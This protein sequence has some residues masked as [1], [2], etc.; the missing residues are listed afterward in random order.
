[1]FQLERTAQLWGITGNLGGGKSLSAVQFAVDAMSRGYFVCSNITLNQDTIALHYGEFTRKLY[2]HISL[3]DPLFDPFKLPCGSP[4]GSGGKK[5]VLII[6]D[7]CAE[8]VDQY[9][10]AKDPRISRLWSWLRHSS[11]RSQ[12]VFIVVQ[13]PD[14]L[15]K[16]IRILITRWIWVHDLAVYRIPVL[17]MRFPFCGGLV[18]RNIFDNMKNRIGAVSFASKSYWGRFYN[19]AECLNS[20]GATYALEY[21]VPEV[22]RYGKFWLLLFL[23]F[24][25]LVLY[26]SGVRA[27]STSLPD[28]EMYP[29]DSPPA[30]PHS[31]IT[32]LT[33]VLKVAAERI[34]NS[35]MRL[36]A[37]SH[38]PSVRGFPCFVPRVPMA[39]FRPLVARAD[40]RSA[41][42]APTRLV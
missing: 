9:S 33:S 13:R 36:F 27:S 18:M 42:C 15:N 19:T 6:L 24:S 2:Q 41:P 26:K 31:A 30:F 5:R 4:R 12:D 32:P 29:D 34:I 22:R 17:K 28:L 1:M 25:Q 11:K 20:D 14:Y 38:C 40:V 3:D 7:E 23:A 37:L 10:S 35:N 21:E 8:W 16:V 39:V